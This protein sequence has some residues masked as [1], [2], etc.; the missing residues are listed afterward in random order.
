MEAEVVNTLFESL[1]QINHSIEKLTTRLEVLERDYRER[2]LKRQMFKWLMAIYPF[3]LLIMLVLI[4]ADHHKIAEITGD[5]KELIND[6]R[7]LTG[8]VTFARVDD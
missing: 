5:V 1:R 2:G 4:D 6:T 8:T 3:F 7:D